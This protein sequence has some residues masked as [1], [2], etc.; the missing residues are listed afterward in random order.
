MIFVDLPYNSV[1]RLAI[2]T[3]ERVRAR[4]SLDPGVQHTPHNTRPV[5][6]QTA[7]EEICM[8]LS[9]DRPGPVTLT[10][11]SYFTVEWS[12]ILVCAAALLHYRASN[13]P[14]GGLQCCSTRIAIFLRES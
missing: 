6:G 9:H 13:Q 5:T 2:G 7:P 3:A 14:K 10:P 11:D 1:L 4:E 8:R 12:W